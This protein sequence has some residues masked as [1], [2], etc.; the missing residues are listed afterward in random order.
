MAL[1]VWLVRFTSRKT[2]KMVDKWVD[3]LRLTMIGNLTMQELDEPEREGRE[4]SFSNK[5]AK[6]KQNQSLDLIR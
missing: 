1:T 2:I 3:L 4:K 6:K 5:H